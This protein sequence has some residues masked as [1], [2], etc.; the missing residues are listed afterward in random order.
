MYWCKIIHSIYLL[1]P[2]KQ[3]FSFSTSHVS[4]LCL[5]LF[6]FHQPRTNICLLL[7]IVSVL[8]LISVLISLSLGLI[9]C[10]VI[11]GFVKRNHWFLSLLMN[12]LQLRAYFPFS[13]ALPL[14]HRFWYIF[15]IIIQFQIFY[16]SSCY[17]F[18]DSWIVSICKLHNIVVYVFGRSSIWVFSSFY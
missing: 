5:S 3:R 6:H 9:C 11:C 14:F 17:F 8:S 1:M 2:V 16:D 10:F 15:F 4:N 12:Y 13:S 7:L 18:F